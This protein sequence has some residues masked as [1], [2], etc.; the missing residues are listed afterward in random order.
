MLREAQRTGNILADPSGDWIDY[1]AAGAGSADELDRRLLSLVDLV[2]LADDLVASALGSQID[3]ADAERWT[4]PILQARAE[5]RAAFAKDEL[6][7][8]AE[9]WVPGVFNTNG[10]LLANA[11]FGLPVNAASDGRGYARMPEVREALTTTGALG[12]LEAVGWEIAGEFATLVETVDEKSAVLDSFA[13]YPKSEILAAA[14]LVSANHGQALGSLAPEHRETLL[15][16]ALSYI[17]TRDRLDVLSDNAIARLMQCQAKARKMLSDRADFVLFDQD[18]F[19]PARTMAENIINAKR[20]FDRKSAWKLLDE[21]MEAAI[22]SAG[23]RD[24]LIRLGL[25]AQLG[26]GGGNLSATARRRVALARALLKRPRLMILDGVAGSANPADT[27]LRAAIRSEL[28]DAMIVFAAASAEAG[29]GADLLVRVDSGGAVQ[30]ETPKVVP[31]EHVSNDS[32][33]VSAGESDAEG[34]AETRM[35]RQAR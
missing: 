35:E 20:R 8:V 13:A 30:C 11:L 14:E 33:S 12:E 21:R 7:D 18:R 19:S 26:S 6:N 29:E 1:A 22:L 31:L 3:A 5:L 17:Q 25:S 27:A 16:L 9:P 2:G 15:A 23:L 10:S 32:D 24:D 4:G 28:P 34:Q